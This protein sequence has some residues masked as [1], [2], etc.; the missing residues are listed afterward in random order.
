VTTIPSARSGADAEAGAARRHVT[1]PVDAGR[2]LALLLVI[3]GAIGLACS[4]VITLEDVNLLKNPHY[5]PSC[6]INPIIS[7][8]S[9]MASKQA[10]VFGFP[11]PLIGLCA[12]S[13]VI[14][15]AAAMLA[16][17]R[18]GG[19]FWL[20]LQGG[21]VFGLGFVHWLMF[22]TLYRIGAVCPYC[23]VVWCT[24]IALFWY[25]LLHNLKRGVI[26]TPVSWQR[27]LK[28]V[29]TYHWVLPVLWYAVIALLILNRF[30][31]YWQTQ[32]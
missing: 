18:F 1:A 26:P 6:N 30:W 25:V 21:T 31:Y 12:F 24:T 4:A 13:V 7:C 17:A 5:V 9:V 14:T 3:A 10:G 15:S 16:G 22:Q 23:C 20:G 27:A 29:Y 2:A 11:N 32:L 19:W 8:G 28:E